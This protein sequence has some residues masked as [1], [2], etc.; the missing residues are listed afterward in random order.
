MVTE[1]NTCLYLL[2]TCLGHMV[3][4][5]VCQVFSKRHFQSLF[6]VTAG[7]HTWTQTQEDQSFCVPL[8]VCELS[9]CVPSVLPERAA[10]LL[11]CVLQQRASDERLCLSAALRH[12]LC[13]IVTHVGLLQQVWTRLLRAPLQVPGQFLTHRRD[14]GWDPDGTRRFSGRTDR[15]TCTLLL[16]SLAS[17]VTAADRV[18]FTRSP[19]EPACRSASCRDGSSWGGNKNIPG[20]L[21]NHQLHTTVSGGEEGARTIFTTTICHHGDVVT[22]V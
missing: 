20:Y 17:V 12:T 16:K 11:A 9:V 19:S 4:Q 15:P 10:D 5:Q 22:L 13:E 3:K 14:P 18:A 7:T 8:S 2:V 21:L 6:Q 1:T